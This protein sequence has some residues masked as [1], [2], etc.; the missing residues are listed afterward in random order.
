[1]RP[2]VLRWAVHG[3]LGLAVAL[4]A[5]HLAEAMRQPPQAAVQ[6]PATAAHAHL[7]SEDTAEV[8]AQRHLFGFVAPLAAVDTPANSSVRVVGIVADADA[9]RSWAILDVDGNEHLAGVG[10]VLA[11]G[12]IIAAVNADGVTLAKGSAERGVAL[13]MPL[14]DIHARFRTLATDVAASDG[15]EQPTNVRIVSTGDYRGVGGTLQALRDR[16]LA[17]PHARRVPSAPPMSHAVQSDD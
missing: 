6:L 8:L 13:N 7:S 3:I 10:D 9:G 12:E 15:S 16:I 5:W 1:V 14:A 17:R 4:S 11:D 2:H